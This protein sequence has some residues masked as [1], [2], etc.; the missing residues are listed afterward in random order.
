MKANDQLMRLLGLVPYLRSRPGV[1]LSEA[2]AAFNITEKQLVADL[3]T[4]WVC[5]L[6]GGL[7]DDLIDIDMD[8]LADD[9]VIHLS[10]ADYLSRPMKLRAD[11]ALGLVAALQ[12]LVDLVPPS[13]QPGVVSALDK[14]K[15][16]L[17]ANQIPVSVEVEAGDGN[18]RDQ[19]LGAIEQGDRIQLTYHGVRRT[20]R[21][22]VDPVQLD[23]VEGYLYLQAWD[24]KADGW[25]S[26]R[27]D[28]IENLVPTVDS[29]IDHGVPPSA[30]QW[31]SS[32][33]TELVLR[34][35]PAANWVVEYFPATVETTDG[36]ITATFP[37]A[38]ESWAIS[39]VLRLGD[40]AEFISPVSIQKAVRAEALKA[41]E[42]YEQLD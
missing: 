6:P 4:L 24:I 27:L 29:A 36:Q 3:N 5:G 26:Y 22:V 11:E 20:T 40:N 2:A 25:R 19:L 42:R 18:I 28:R 35:S 16:I 13:A 23:L 34:L 37:V 7:P 32:P 1:R 21:P 14:L 38:S 31:F 8:A 30:E 17:G 9:G 15:K 33:V 12:A 41:L 10:N 39:L